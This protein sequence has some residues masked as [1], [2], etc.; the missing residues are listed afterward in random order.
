MKKITFSLSFQKK[1]RQL[2]KKD[3]KLFNK[4]KKQITLF[5]ANPKHPSL[6]LH[7]LKGNLK[8]VWSISITINIRVLFVEDSKYYFFDIGTHDQ[9]YKK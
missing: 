9:V 3:Q 6:H 2:Q 1:L 4:I 5:K 8:N 7:K